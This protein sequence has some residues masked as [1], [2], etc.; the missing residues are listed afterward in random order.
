MKRLACLLLC[1]TLLAP[2]LALADGTLDERVARTFKNYR[3]TG[4]ALVV[5][6]D[7]E[8]V[9]E[10]YY[11]YADRRAKTPVTEKTCFRTASVTKMITAIHVMQLVEDGLLDLDE[12]IGAYL[13]YPVVNPHAKDTPTTLRNLMSHTSAL[14]PH[15]GYSRTGSR[16]DELID[17]SH[18]KG[19]SNYYEYRS[20]RKYKYSNFGAGIMGSL[21]EAVTGKNVDDSVREGVFDPLEINAAYHAGLLADTAQVANLYD[22]QGNLT[23]NQSASLR[24]KWDP[25]V[26]P[27]GHFRI[28]IG[29]VWINA[30][31]LCRL[32]MLLCDGGTLD[33]QALLAEET[34][35]EMMSDQKGK[36]NI[37]CETPYGL[38]VN[39]VDNLLKGKMIYGHQGL[40]EG[41]LCNLYFDPETHFV[42]AMVTNGSSTNMDDHIGKLSRKL[43]AIAWENFGGK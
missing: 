15:G 1:L 28:T 4:G 6:K 9:Y 37:T 31:D 7:G 8:I 20:G 25:G 18:T 5:A 19:W 16:L 14:D 13:G 26:D 30:R 3:T 35:A 12:D 10:K 36:G 34:V 40:S 2:A 21:I 27:N 39:R 43:F 33:D 24:R 22:D 32:G 23:M 11:G 38:C 29:S 17:A 42:F 41:I